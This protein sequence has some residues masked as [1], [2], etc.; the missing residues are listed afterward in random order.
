MTD[1]ETIQTVTD[2]VYGSGKAT[3][4]AIGS[5]GLAYIVVHGIFVAVPLFG[6]FRYT[7]YF[8]SKD[9]EVTRAK[10]IWAI[11]NLL[12]YQLLVVIAHVAILS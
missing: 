11:N 8:F 6:V 2:F 9:S 3:P 4:E 1:I 12:I 7:T 5:A 10:L